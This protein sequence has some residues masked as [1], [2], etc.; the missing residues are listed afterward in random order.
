M[1]ASTHPL[2]RPTY[3]SFYTPTP[4]VTGLLKRSG[5]KNPAQTNTLQ[6]KALHKVAPLVKTTYLLFPFH[7]VH[8]KDQVP[9]RQ[10][11]RPYHSHV[12][13]TKAKFSVIP[14]PQ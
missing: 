4:K 1:E 9:D 8:N 2:F 13:C 3:L 11:T 6:S 12:L 5:K 10:K 7:T 14:V